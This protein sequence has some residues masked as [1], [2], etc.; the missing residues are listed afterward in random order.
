MDFAALSR[1]QSKNK[2]KQ[3]REISTLTLQENKKKLWNMKVTLIPI[4]IGAI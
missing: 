4:V 1:P 3:K 2:R